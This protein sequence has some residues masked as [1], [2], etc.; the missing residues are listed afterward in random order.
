MISGSITNI[1][2]GA[3][4]MQEVLFQWY[5]GVTGVALAVTDASAA[6]KDSPLVG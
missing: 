5:S 3:E 4:V 6:E 2:K 1:S